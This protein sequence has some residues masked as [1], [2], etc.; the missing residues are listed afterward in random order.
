MIGNLCHRPEGGV[1]HVMLY[2]YTHGRYS[3]D[4]LLDAAEI[5]EVG[6]SWREAALAN[7][8]AEREQAA[9]KNKRR[10]RGS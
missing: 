4:D 3:L 6:R 9:A 5:D 2:E 7:G 1:D 8:R 10:K